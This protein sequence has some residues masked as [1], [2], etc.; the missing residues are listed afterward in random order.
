MVSLSAIGACGGTAAKRNGGLVQDARDPAD[1]VMGAGS[2]AVLAGCAP[3]SRRYQ[4]QPS[5]RQ[6]IRCSRFVS[7][8]DSNIGAIR[9]ISPIHSLVRGSVGLQ[10]NSLYRNRSK[11]LGNTSHG[12]CD[13]TGNVRE[14]TADDFMVPLAAYVDQ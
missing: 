13:M 5:P 12:L 14:W 7:A 9:Q 11:P 1:D 10:S 4:S 2:A 6:E 8:Y 3:P